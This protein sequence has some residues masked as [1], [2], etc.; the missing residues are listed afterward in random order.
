MEP[1]EISRIFQCMVNTASNSKLGATILVFCDNI[2]YMREIQPILDEHKGDPDNRN[3]KLAQ[4][5]NNAIKDKKLRC[6][7]LC[8]EIILDMEQEVAPN[9]LT[10]YVDAKKEIGHIY[11]KVEGHYMFNGLTIDTVAIT[12]GFPDLF[13]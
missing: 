2:P 6:L 9:L 4:V 13:E 11:E 12:Y 3:K 7:F 8:A 1:K 10:L 5:I